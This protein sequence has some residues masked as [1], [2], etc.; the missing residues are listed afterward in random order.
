LT[1]NQISNEF[2]LFQTLTDSKR[3][4]LAQNLLNKI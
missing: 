4:S 2:R 3:A 1:R